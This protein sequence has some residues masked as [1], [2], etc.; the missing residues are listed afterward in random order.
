LELESQLPAARARL[1]ALIGRSPDAPLP[2]PDLPEP[3][4][5]PDDALLLAVGTRA[6]PELAALGRDVAGR[7][8]A[9]DL[10]RQQYL[11]DINPFAGITG[12][13]EQVV[14]AAITLATTIPQIQ[15]G[16]REARANLRA[17]EALARQGELDREAAFV[18]ALLALRSAERQRA[19]LERHVMASAQQAAAAA[20]RAYA[21]GSGDF[22]TWLAAQRTL[23]ELRLTIAE[24][25][26]AR[27]RRVAELELLAGV[28]AERLAALA[29]S[30]EGRLA[31]VGGTEALAL[32]SAAG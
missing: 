27:E 23:L 16:I 26:V 2:P 10:A 13:M 8:E 25:R 4:P 14:G 21:T 6:N 12:S 9:L 20:E 22:A 7:A 24:T 30:E 1:N 32:T 17:S 5:L 15:A 11:P 19:V 31:L 29:E 3:R 18:A 28:D